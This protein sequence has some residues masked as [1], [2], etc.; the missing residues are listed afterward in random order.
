MHRPIVIVTGANG[1]LGIE[2]VK[3]LWYKEWNVITTYRNN[4]DKLRAFAK[5]IDDDTTAARSSS[6]LTNASFKVH[7]TDPVEIN[8]FAEKVLKLYGTPWAVINLAGS[9]SNAMS[10]KLDPDEFTMILNE[11]L[12]ST[13][14]VNRAFTPSM[15]TAGQGRII[16]TS[17]IVGETGIAGASH[18]AAAKAGIIGLTKSLALELAPKNIT[19]NALGLG[20]FDVGL[21][22]DVPRSMIDAIIEKTPLKRL[23]TASDL[24]PTIQFLL[25]AGSSFITGQTININGGLT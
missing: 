15:R 24:A 6:A 5:E 9:S 2:V 22:N 21:I 18:Y 3:H 19:V 11:N 23:G 25:S 10:W 7:L 8:A 17:S 12:M 14:L 20:Y 1:G 13:F 16:N 4:D